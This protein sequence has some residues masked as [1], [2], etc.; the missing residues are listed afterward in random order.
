MNPKSILL[1]NPWIHDFI[2]YSLWIKPIGL[3]YLASILKQNGHHVEFIDCLNSLR[4]QK[5]DGRGNF[6]ETILENPTILRNVPKKYRRYGISTDD[7]KSRLTKLK[8]PDLIFVTSIMTYW[9]P[10]VFYT[11]KILKEHFPKTRI[12]LGGIY[13]KLCHEHAVKYSQ[14]DYV[15]TNVQENIDQFLPDIKFPTNFSKIPYP[16]YELYGDLNYLVIMSSL[17]CPYSCT[18]CA[19]KMLSGK[20]VRKNPESIINEIIYWSKIKKIKDLIF[21]DDALFFDPDNHIKI[22]LKELNNKEIKTNIHLPNGVN[23]GPID[24]ELANLLLLNGIKTLNFSLETIN[25]KLQKEKSKN[26]ITTSIFSK[27]IKILEKAGFDLGNIGIYIMMGLPSQKPDE[28]YDTIRFVK[29]FGLKPKLNEFSPVPMTSD[30]E[31]EKKAVAVDIENEPLWHNNTLL[32]MR[33]KIF[34]KKVV[35]ELKAYAKNPNV[36]IQ[37]TK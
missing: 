21:T 19:S 28:V 36:K 4:K 24:S 37:M 22:I 33:S 35:D 13:A 31:E 23:I 27:N 9:Y 7:F 30:F 34:N 17:G 12:I 8:E 18:Y 5:Q 20:Y 26:K 3:L 32:F 25:P 10:G 29:N 11:I 16:A 2:A 14:A 15:S 6:S 1:V